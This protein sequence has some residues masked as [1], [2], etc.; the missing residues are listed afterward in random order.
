MSNEKPLIGRFL[1]YQKERFPFLTHGILIG[2]FTFSAIA[3]ARLSAGFDDFI[4]WK[5][6]AVCLFNTIGI[7]F[8]L[9]VFDEHKDLE[10]DQRY[11]PD[12]PVSRGLIS[13]PEL[14]IFG[15]SF[16][17]L[18]VAID[19]W[20]YPKILLPLG[21]VMV[22]MVLMGKEFFVAEW[23][24]A[25]QFWY[26][27]SHML[28]IPFV[29]V[30]ASSFDW[31][32]DG[33]QAPI[34]LAIFFAVSFMNGIVLEVG[35][36]LR[37]PD[38]EREGVLTYSSMLGARKAIHLW[39]VC[40]FATATLAAFACIYGGFH[41]ACLIVLTMNLLLCLVVGLRYRGNQSSKNAKTMEV[42]SG[43][44]SIMMYLT[45]GGLPFLLT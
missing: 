8:L 37:A 28:I 25:R 2:A 38:E 23:L 15:I 14:R 26:V 27:V 44:W 24:K 21:L 43:I 1:T 10:D 31:Y 35:R 45:I 20:L 36:K 18:M 4:E 17:V 5:R 39:I 34:G 30:F 33:R 9:R 6:F 41:P 16:F 29:D 7:F 40:L 12:L 11:R 22:W 42:I 3:Y 19:L 32:I 13:L